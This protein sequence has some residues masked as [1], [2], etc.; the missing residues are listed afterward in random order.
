MTYIAYTTEYSYKME[1]IEARENETMHHN[2][3]YVL[4]TMPEG[5]F[6]YEKATKKVHLANKAITS[7]LTRGYHKTHESHNS[8]KDNFSEE[9]PPANC[10]NKPSALGTVIS[11]NRQRHRGRY[12]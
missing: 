4:E 11:A 5:I 12:N 9:R 1:F 2:L 6:V 3:Q 10:R 7:L 8:V